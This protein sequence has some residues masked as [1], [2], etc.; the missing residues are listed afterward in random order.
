MDKE[1]HLYLDDYEVTRASY[2]LHSYVAA[3][4]AI[5]AGQYIIHT[6]QL[7]L[8]GTYLFHAGYRIFIYPSVGKPFEITL[9]KCANT[10]REIRE[11]HNLEKLLVNGEFDTDSVNVCDGPGPIVLHKKGE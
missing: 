7:A 8:V 9:G 10:S 1:F 11:S 3:K 2:C 5:E 4:K 6:T